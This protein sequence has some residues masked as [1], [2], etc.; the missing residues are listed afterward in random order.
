MRDWREYK[1]KGYLN[2][3][4]FR[5]PILGAKGTNLGDWLAKDTIQEPSIFAN[6]CP[7][8]RKKFEN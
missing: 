4:G 3:K 7:F 1:H 2:V 5:G 8:Q 6:D